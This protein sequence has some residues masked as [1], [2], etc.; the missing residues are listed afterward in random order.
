MAPRCEVFEFLPLVQSPKERVPQEVILGIKIPN[1]L[2]IPK[3]SSTFRLL[4][5]TSVRIRIFEMLALG[6][7]LSGEKLYLH[8]RIVLNT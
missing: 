6:S 8:L 3:F 2:K 1:E 7:V 4:S 5:N